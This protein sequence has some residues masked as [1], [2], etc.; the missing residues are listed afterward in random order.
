MPKLEPLSPDSDSDRESSGAFSTPLGREHSTTYTL[1]SSTLCL[2]VPL[3]IER[4]R[5]SG[6][7]YVL[8][9]AK[10][11]SQHIAEH[12]DVILYRSKKKGE[13]AKAFNALAEGV[14]CLSFVPGGVKI[15]G[16]HWEAIIGE[17]WPSK[18]TAGLIEIC[19]SMESLLR[20]GNGGGV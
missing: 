10:E 5:H 12:R 11:C 1:L 3:W 6:W 20:D 14:A 7:E 13:T 15:F 4:L 9:R 18:A 17:D 16:S 19:K 8:G 2:A